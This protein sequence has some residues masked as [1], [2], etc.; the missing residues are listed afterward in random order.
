MKNQPL[1]FDFID[2]S[3]ISEILHVNVD[4]TFFTAAVDDAV[5]ELR[6]PILS[7][8]KHPD[9][10]VISFSAFLRIIAVSKNSANLEAYA[11]IMEILYE[12]GRI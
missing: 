8:K 2:M 5:M 1:S 4:M 6:T 7:C 3:S 9:K 11:I 12:I 10:L